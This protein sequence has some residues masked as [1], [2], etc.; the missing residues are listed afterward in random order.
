[1][2]TFLIQNI[3]LTYDIHDF[4][5]FWVNLSNIYFSCQAAL[6]KLDAY[7]PWA[8]FSSIYLSYL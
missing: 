3:H 4:F 8:K 1:M 7:L 2:N 6:K 5:I